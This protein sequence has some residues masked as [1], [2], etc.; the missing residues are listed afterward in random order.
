MWIYLRNN[1]GAFRLQG[2][3]VFNSIKWAAVFVV[4]RLPEHKNLVGQIRPAKGNV[5]VTWPVRVEHNKGVV[6]P[7]TGN[8][9]VLYAHDPGF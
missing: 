9:V 7:Y 2:G 3:Y 5:A 8:C 4:G 6:W 1:P